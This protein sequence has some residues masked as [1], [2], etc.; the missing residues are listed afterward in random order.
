MTGGEVFFVC[1]YL[2]FFPMCI[3]FLFLCVFFPPQTQQPASKIIKIETSNIET[4]NI[5]HPTSNIQSNIH[6]N[7]H[8]NPTSNIPIIRSKH[9]TS[10]IQ[11]FN[12]AVILCLFV[13]VKR[14]KKGRKRE[15][16]GRKKRK[17][18][19]FAASHTVGLYSALATA[20]HQTER[21]WASLLRSPL[22]CTP[23][24][25]T[26]YEP[27]GQ[28]LRG[29]ARRFFKRRKR[30]CCAHAEAYAHKHLRKHANLMKKH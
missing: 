10:S 5:Q 29:L 25:A 15:K 13:C 12:H 19:C 4:S 14:E 1:E 9:P 30:A 21:S 7:Q 22:A 8:S 18:L 11:S 28:G 3:A 26:A 23:R 20:Y 17:S 24:L 6:P 16:M 27:K 2:L